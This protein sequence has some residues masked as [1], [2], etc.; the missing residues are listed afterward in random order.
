MNRKIM[1]VMSLVLVLS[2]VLAACAAPTAA[3][4]TEAPATEAPA[5]TEAPTT[6]P[7]EK[8]VINWWHISTKDPASV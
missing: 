1:L 2:F 5:A 7:A 3:P 8:V 6:A 4:A